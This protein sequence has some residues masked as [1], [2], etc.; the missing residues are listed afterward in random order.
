MLEDLPEAA[1]VAAADDADALRFRVAEERGM[2]DHFV[3][4]VAVVFGHHHG[5][6]EAE[7][8][9]V[10]VGVEDLYFLEPARRGEHRVFDL[11][12]N[13]GETVDKV[14]EPYRGSDA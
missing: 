4:G 9:A 7:H 3:I 14:V 12:G 11:D 10:P 2:H 6:A 13:A 8:H 1:A 5:A